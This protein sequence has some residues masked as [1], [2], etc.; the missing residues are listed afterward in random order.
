[1]LLPEQPSLIT[2]PSGVNLRQV[3]IGLDWLEHEDEED[4]AVSKRASHATR[5]EVEGYCAVPNTRA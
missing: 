4:R 2:S 5:T 1:M 3:W